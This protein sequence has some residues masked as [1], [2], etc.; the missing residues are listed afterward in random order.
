MAAYCLLDAERNVFL[1]TPRRD[2]LLSGLPLVSVPVLHCGLI[3]SIAQL[4]ALIGR[5]RFIRPGHLNRQRASCV[6][7]GLD[8]AIP[9]RETEPSSDMEELYIKVEESGTVTG[10]YKYI[11]TG[12]LTSVLNAESHWPDRP[13]IP[14]LLHPDVDLYG[15]ASLRDNS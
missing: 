1:A 14:N 2:S 9:L 10:R 15:P 6:T 8:P 5:S 4:A 7:R 13:I 11:R 3:Q 12:F